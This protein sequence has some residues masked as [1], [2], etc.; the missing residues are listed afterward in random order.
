MI[1]AG[2]LSDE[3]V[4]DI[5]D[6]KA[7]GQDAPADHPGEGKPDRHQHHALAVSVLIAS[8]ASHCPTDAMV[9]PAGGAGWALRVLAL[10]GE[11]STGSQTSASGP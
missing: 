5:V 7:D 8:R 11:R 6:G 1:M 4:G 9:G 3:P 2:L 10:C